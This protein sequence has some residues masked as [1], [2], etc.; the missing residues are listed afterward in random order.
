MRKSL[1]FRPTTREVLE[2]T[3]AVM[4]P[5][6]GAAQALADA[7]NHDGPVAFYIVGNKSY[8]VEKLPKDSEHPTKGATD[9]KEAS[10]DTT[11]QGP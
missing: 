7:N 10:N 6:S 4:G 5:N 11:M 2:K 8:L 1:F 3:A 9:S